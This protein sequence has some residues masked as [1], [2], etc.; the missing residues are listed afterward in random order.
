MSLNQVNW[1]NGLMMTDNM[2]VA[3]GNIV[4]VIVVIVVIRG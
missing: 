1:H 2:N 3:I 4:V